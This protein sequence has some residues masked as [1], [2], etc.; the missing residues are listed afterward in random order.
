MLGIMEVYGYMGNRGI[1]DNKIKN[2]FPLYPIPIYHNPQFALLIQTN[3]NTH[4]KIK[5][6]IY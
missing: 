5:N 3:D 4:L 1:L 2:L 6:I